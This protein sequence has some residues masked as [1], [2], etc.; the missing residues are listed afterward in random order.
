MSD[1]QEY[2][3]DW[4]SDDQW[5]CAKLAA[6]FKYGFHHLSNLRRWGNGIAIDEPN[7]IA[8]YDFNGLTRLVVMAHDECVRVG[9]KIETRD[10]EYEGHQYQVTKLIVTFHP[11]KRPVDGDGMSSRHPELDHHIAEIRA[12]RK[13]EST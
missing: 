1:E 7:E 3:K 13:A 8:T 9:V 10:E 5:K 2:R 4:M 6:E 11:C 12:G